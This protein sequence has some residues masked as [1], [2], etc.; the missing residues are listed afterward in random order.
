MQSK[1]NFFESEESKLRSEVNRLNAEVER[2]TNL[3][4]NAESNVKE[5]LR[6]CLDGKHRWLRIE[7][8]LGG[9]DELVC[10]DCG[11]KRYED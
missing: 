7:N 4:E 3:V 8:F 11:K 2:L 5:K 10:M 6:D 9:P 1:K